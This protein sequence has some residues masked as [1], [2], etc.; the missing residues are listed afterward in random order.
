MKSGY[1]IGGLAAAGAAYFVY[2]RYFNKRKFAEVIAN[3][4]K[5]SPESYMGLDT[6]YLR[7]RANAIQSGQSSFTF[8]G[9]NYATETGKAI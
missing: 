8:K 5:T 4:K 1:I 9:R 7:S 2:D 3:Y 6:G